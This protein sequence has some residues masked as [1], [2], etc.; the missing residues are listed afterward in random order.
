MLRLAN[1]I[2]SATR[3]VA[4]VH[5]AALLALADATTRTRFTSAIRNSS[6][7]ASC[8]MEYAVA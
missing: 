2:P 7:A 1:R 6:F 3:V 5:G 8:T 4:F